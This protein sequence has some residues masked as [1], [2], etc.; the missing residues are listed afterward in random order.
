[1]V[2]KQLVFKK[3]SHRFSNSLV[4]LR[5]FDKTKLKITQHNYVD[6]SI[7]HIDYTKL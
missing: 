3:G 7:Y 1:M 6:R 2:I 4:L 5:D